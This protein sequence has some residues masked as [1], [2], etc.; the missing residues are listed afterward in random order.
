[1]LCSLDRRE[2]KKQD[3]GVPDE[4]WVPC[5]GQPSVALH[6]NGLGSVS[7]VLANVQVGR[8]RVRKGDQFPPGG[9]SW[10]EAERQSFRRNPDGQQE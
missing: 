8:K 2:E 10:T 5:R 3:L 4:V 9:E 6:L 1:M 7:P